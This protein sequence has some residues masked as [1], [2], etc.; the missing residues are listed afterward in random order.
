MIGDRGVGGRGGFNCCLWL[1]KGMWCD[2]RRLTKRRGGFLER[3][4]SFSWFLSY[5]CC[6][7]I[8][9][10]VSVGQQRLSVDAV[11]TT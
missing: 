1:V 10:D 6:L 2:G 8:I 4:L 3:L 11:F 5:Q 9:V 7:R